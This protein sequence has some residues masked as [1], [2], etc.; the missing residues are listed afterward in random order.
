VM[1][2]ALPAI[3]QPTESAWLNS[4]MQR[5]AAIPARQAEFVEEKHIAALSQPLISRGQL[6]YRR[7]SYIAKITF[8]PRPETLIANGDQL[9]LGSGNAAPRT[10]SLASYPAVGVLVDGIRAALAGDLPTL[11]RFYRI[12]VEGNPTAWRLV[13]TPTAPS[14]ARF[15]RTL[16]LEG[17]NTVVRAIRIR[18]TNGDEQG[19]T[20]TPVR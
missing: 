10:L 7:P 6:I 4:L 16:T 5:M 19:M 18:E 11:R 8:S 3:A 20:I 13:L 12:L 14:L 17:S 1:L 15:L 9:S 2:P